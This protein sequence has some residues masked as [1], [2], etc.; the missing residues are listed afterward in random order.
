MKRVAIGIIVFALFVA[1]VFGI[2][3]ISEFTGGE[4]PASTNQTGPEEKKLIGQP[5]VFPN[6]VCKF[7]P[8]SEELQNRMFRGF[9][10]IGETDTAFFWFKNRSPLPVTITSL[11]ASCT[12]C[13]AARITHV[14]PESLAE[15]AKTI[16]ISGTIGSLIPGAPNLLDAFAFQKFEA[17]LPWKTIELTKLNSTLELPA[18]GTVE[19]PG[20][21]IVQLQMK[22]SA[23]GARDPRVGIKAGVADVPPTTYELQMMFVVVG[24]FAVRPQNND[25]GELAEGAKPRPIEIICWS[26]TRE[27]GDRFPPPVLRP[28]EDDPFV[29]IAAPVRL[30]PDELEK[31]NAQLSAEMKGPNRC[32]AA[33]RYW[34]TVN[35]EVNGKVADIGPFTKTIHVAGSLGEKASITVTGSVT[36]VIR[37]AEGKAVDFGTYE[38]R[39]DKA[40]RTTLL[41]DQK[42]MDLEVV[43]GETKPRFL[44]PTL[45]SPTI[46]GGA[47]VWKLNLKVN[48]NEGFQANWNGFVVLRS[49]G[50]NPIT[51]RVP[52]TGNGVRR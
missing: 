33:Y 8:N 31:L 15:Y 20:L 51:I 26:A 34:V 22:A 37:L 17:E 11:G 7:D 27:F 6:S 38:A 9:Y 42:D 25:V 5:L 30:T 19:K 40:I 16:A 50:P 12:T 13:S 2:V 32:L 43:A 48:A 46:E 21:G 28:H 44:K 45:E 4:D 35:R 14:S 24:N 39:F 29:S 23:G 52:V 47:K 1:M 41:S 10:E 49:K 3:L 36:G 18:G